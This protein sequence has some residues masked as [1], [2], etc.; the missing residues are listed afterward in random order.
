[1]IKL[2]DILQILLTIVYLI[3]HFFLRG[4]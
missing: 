4:I 3:L 1:M 2:I